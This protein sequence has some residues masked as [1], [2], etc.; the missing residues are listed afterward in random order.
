MK[1]IITLIV[2]VVLFL[3]AVFLVLNWDDIRLNYFLDRYN[4]I[5]E[6][7]SLQEL[8]LTIYAI[9][10]W[11]LTQAPVSKETIMTGFQESKLTI[12]VTAEELAQ[13]LEQLKAL[14]SDTIQTRD[15]QADYIDMRLYYV[16][17]AGDKEILDVSLDAYL[18]ADSEGYISANGDREDPDILANAFVNGIMVKANPA[19]YEA[20]LP[21]LSEEDREFL[22][23]YDKTINNEGVIS[24]E[25]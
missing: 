3:S 17:K 19:L 2:A 21:F 16:I 22:G 24:R 20:I 1:R 25:E 23:L 14:N 5:L 12:V 9:Q 18:K 15:V 10:P 11:T 8:T 4:R 6:E 7:E 13:S